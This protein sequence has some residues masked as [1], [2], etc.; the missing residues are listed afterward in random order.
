MEIFLKSC[1]EFDVDIEDFYRYLMRSYRNEILML[2]LSV[3][4]V[5]LILY[6]FDSS[7][8]IPSL[9]STLSALVFLQFVKLNMCKDINASSDFILKYFKSRKNFEGILLRF[10][11]YLKLVKR[12][13]G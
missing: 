10:E 13:K 6:S 7:C 3:V 8:M 4:S 11:I 5:G 1:R 2:E 12:I 9:V